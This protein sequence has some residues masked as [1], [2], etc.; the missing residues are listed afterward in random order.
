MAAMNDVQLIVTI[1]RSDSIELNT[2]R[3]QWQS[4]FLLWQW[5]QRKGS[6]WDR[7]WFFS[8]M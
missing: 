6:Q 4:N 7:C 3:W 2:S 8:I 1:Q 5:G